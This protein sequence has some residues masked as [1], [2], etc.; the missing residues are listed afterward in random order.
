MHRIRL[1][2]ALMVLLLPGVLRAQVGVYAGFSATKLNVANTD[3]IKGASFGA[4]YDPIHLPLVNFGID[5]RG[6]VLGGSGAT[7]VKSGLIGPRAVVHLPILPLKPYVEGLI[8]VGQVQVG[9]GVAATRSGTQFEY[10]LA[11]GV[12][13]TFFPRL[14]WRVVDYQYGAFNGSNSTTSQKTL[15]TG[16]VFRLPIP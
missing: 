9:Q 4:Y 5:A 12:D 3:W 15:S 10:G 16:L 14:D 11:A 8:G 2:L 6:S 7:Q 13:F 1:V